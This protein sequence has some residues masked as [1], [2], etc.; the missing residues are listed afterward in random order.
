[1][2]FLRC[3]LTEVVLPLGSHPSGAWFI[4]GILPVWRL[5]VLLS[6]LVSDEDRGIAWD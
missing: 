6:L 3:L 1:M 4:I 5:C 2:V